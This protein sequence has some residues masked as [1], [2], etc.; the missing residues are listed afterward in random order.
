MTKFLALA[1]Q[2]NAVR[3]QVEFSYASF[4]FEIMVCFRKETTGYYQPDDENNPR[5]HHLIREKIFQ[6]LGVAKSLRIIGNTF[7]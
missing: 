6:L 7:W 5:F 4:R 2:E 1:V 3:Q